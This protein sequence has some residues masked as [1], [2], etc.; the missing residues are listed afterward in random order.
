M[1][2]TVLWENQRGAEQGGFVERLTAVDDGGGRRAEPVA[3]T[4]DYLFKIK[5]HLKIR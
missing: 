2:D 5:W 1:T 3:K 4:C